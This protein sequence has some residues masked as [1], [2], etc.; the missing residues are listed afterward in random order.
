MKKL[1]RISLFFSMIACATICSC[2][3]VLSADG[4]NKISHVVVI[5]VD[6]GGAFFKQADTPNLDRIFE[7][8]AVSYEVITSKP[9]ISAQ[10]W[11]SMLHGVTPE[12]H[13]LTNGIVSSTP[14]PTDS[15]FP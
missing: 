13:G 8:G 10:C 15:I 14:F 6:G 5:G 2:G 4:G 9:T 11:G 12:F 1:Q 3:Q 7:N